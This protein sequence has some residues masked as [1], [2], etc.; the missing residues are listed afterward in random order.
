M[1]S[2][3]DGLMEQ[4]V[5]NTQPV[6][7]VTD[8]SPSVTLCRDQQQVNCHHVICP[9]YAAV[10][11]VCSAS[12]LPRVTEFTGVEVCEL[13]TKCESR[14]ARIQASQLPKLIGLFL[15]F[16]VQRGRWAFKDM[17]LKV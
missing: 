13:Q 7:T 10:M 16:E 11:D 6:L 14:T 17:S 4:G 2:S 3:G 9:V 15:C 1:Q 8:V 12:S 5:T